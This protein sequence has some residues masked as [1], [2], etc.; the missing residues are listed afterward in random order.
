M[1]AAY[2]PPMFPFSPTGKLFASLPVFAGLEDVALD[3]LA[4]YAVEH[5]FEKGQYIVNEGD[6]G[7]DLF[8][9][10]Q[11]SV[12]IVKRAG[13]ENEVVLATLRERDFFGE[14]CLIE[15]VARS[16]SVRAAE[17]AVVYALSARSL[18]VFYKKWPEQHAIII[19]N[20][21]RDVS[22]R[23]RALDEAFCARAD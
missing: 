6:Q 4:T 9:L 14:M 15:C 13:T 23:L 22:R 12:E 3:L 8:I 7:N 17:P 21:A 5:T 1:I 19:L 11:G 16:A 2:V 20:I 10:G 18:L